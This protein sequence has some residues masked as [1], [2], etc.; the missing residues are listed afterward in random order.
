MTN[1]TDIVKPEGRGEI[2]VKAMNTDGR[3]YLEPIPDE[4]F[5]GLTKVAGVAS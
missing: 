3:D 5:V 1:F 4:E 2:L